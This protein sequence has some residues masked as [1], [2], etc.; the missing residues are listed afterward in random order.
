MSSLPVGLATDDTQV[1]LL[2]ASLA[3]LPHACL[4]HHKKVRKW[5]KK[6]EKKKQTVAEVLTHILLAANG[7]WLETI[8]NNLTLTGLAAVC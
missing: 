4:T 1:L 8:G 3:N 6:K 2:R 7:A 5:R